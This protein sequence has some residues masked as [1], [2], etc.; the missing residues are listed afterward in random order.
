[1][2]P[3]IICFMEY[4]G[5]VL[6]HLRLGIILSLLAGI[7]YCKH[8]PKSFSE[9]FGSH[10][11]IT[12][13][14]FHKHDTLIDRVFQDFMSSELSH[15]FCRKQNFMAKPSVMQRQL[16]GEGSHRRLTSSIRIEIQPE[17]ISKLHSLSCEAIV[18]ERLPSGVFADP[19][20]LEHLTER[21]VFSGASAFGDT[22]LELPTVRANRSV[23]EVHMDLS[24]NSLSGNKNGLELNIELPLHAR[25]APLGKQGYTRVEFA[26]P[27]LFVHCIVEGDPLNQSCIFSST[28]EAVRSNSAAIVWQVPSGIVKHTK[29]VSV[30][31]FIAAV[32]GAL[33]IFMACIFYSEISVYNGSKQS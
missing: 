12:E 24:P 26:S 20:E 23:V 28:N 8:A 27:D 25:Y 15:G 2:V 32:V 30:L 5:H 16:T 13:A 1:M 14:Y 29:I 19:F 6:V 11:Y 31:T 10:K 22:D 9:L 4:Q 7:T 3:C 33:S 21:G 17:V 18:I